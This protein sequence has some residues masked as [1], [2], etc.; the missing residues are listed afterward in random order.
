[1]VMKRW[2]GSVCG[3]VVVVAASACHRAD[4]E[5][6]SA[7][8]AGDPATA[9]NGQRDAD[10]SDVDC[11]GSIT[12]KCGSGAICTVDLNCASALCASGICSPSPGGGEDAGAPSTEPDCTITNTCASGP[13]STNPGCNLGQGSDPTLCPPDI[14]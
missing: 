14:H 10:E 13:P 2:L 9:A 1:M 12:P 7:A 4:T 3:I 6:G 11:G 8:T 5:P